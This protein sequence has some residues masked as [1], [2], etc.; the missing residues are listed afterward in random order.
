MP[1]ASWISA[2]HGPKSLNESVNV[3]ADDVSNHEQL[4]KIDAAFSALDVRYE[5][6]MPTERL[7]DLCLR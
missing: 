1:W 6:L 3:Q 7:S 4:N 2:R 5:W